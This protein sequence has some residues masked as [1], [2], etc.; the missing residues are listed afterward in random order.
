[1]YFGKDWLFVGK[2]WTKIDGS[3][4]DLTIESDEWHRNNTA[5]VVWETADI[6]LEGDALKNIK[7]LAYAEA[8]TIRFEGRDFYQDF[9]PGPKRLMSMREVIA[10]YE[11]AAE[12]EIK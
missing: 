5:N 11:S 4:V 8:P 10:A 9:K 6:S 3:A 7:R 2:A 12:K 1:M